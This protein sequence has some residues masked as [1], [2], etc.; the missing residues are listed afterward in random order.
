MRRHLLVIYGFARL[1]DDL[2]DEAPGDRLALLDGLSRQLD[3]V[4]SGRRPSHPLMQR[5]FE[6]VVSRELP[7]EPFD[8]LIQAN[9][10]DQVVTRYATFGELVAYCRLS[11]APVGELVLRLADACTPG[12]LALSEATCVGLQL[13]EFWQDL[14]EDAR[15]GRVYVPLEDVRRFGCEPRQFLESR[16]DEPFRR[17]MAFEAERT[18]SFLE[19]GR[20]L[21]GMLG[22]RLGLA[23]RLF[24]AGGLAALDDL[25]R[26]GYDTFATSGRVSRP[27]LLAAC[28][29][30]LARGPAPWRRRLHPGGGR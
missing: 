16:A 11:A 24:T 29:R 28:L 25:R 6:T 13:A 9:R 15:Q 18:R 10:Q 23:V 21:G 12:T 7:R 20:P 27:R 4:F 17:L 8:K 2:G 14:G 3:D 5:L 22:G 30:E 26:R 19:E 1:V